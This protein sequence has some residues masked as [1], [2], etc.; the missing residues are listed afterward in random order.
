[1]DGKFE[2]DSI[3]VFLGPSLPQIQARE[4]LDASYYP[5]ARRGDVYRIMTSGIDTI[6]LIDGVFHNAPSVWQRELL[7]AIE[8][9]FSVFGA[10]SM[11]AL[12]AAELYEFGMIGHGVVFE[13]YRD[14]VIDGDDEVALLHATEEFDFRPL[15]VPLVNIR[16][17]LDRAVE[18]RYLTF[19]Q[20]VGVLEHLERMPY[21]ERSFQAVL[22]SPIFKDPSPEVIS[23]LDIYLSD[24][25]V[26]IKMQD[27]LGLLHR[28]KTTR[29]QEKEAPRRT[30][31]TSV[32]K[33]QY[34]RALMTGFYTPDGAIMGVEI[35]QRIQESKRF[36]EKMRRTLSLRRFILEWINQNQVH[37]P[38]D[39]LKT[40][41][42]NFEASNN[43]SDFAAWLCKNGL[44]Y[45]SFASALSELTLVDWVNMKGPGHFGLRW[46]TRDDSIAELVITSPPIASVSSMVLKKM[47]HRDG[48][49]DVGDVFQGKSSYAQYGFVI[50]WANRNGISAEDARSLRESDDDADIQTKNYLAWT[51]SAD[52]T[53]SRRAWKREVLLADWVVAQ[54]PEHFGLDWIFEL[55]LLRILQLTDQVELFDLVP[56]QTPVA[57]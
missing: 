48:V 56:A 4:I 49:D 8:E 25:A 37:C 28:V 47:V 21:P 1:M 5:P 13:W 18:D 16:Y 31:T 38:D 20:K 41:F 6:V 17:T 9:G 39:V 35:L 10:S 34:D 33:Q 55:D 46:N 53:S 22:D 57:R 27:A 12:R 2:Q 50:E 40:A 44:T 23:R 29:T 14:G 30:R 45:S 24:K 3:A 51:H 11:G 19:E 36:L 54:G 52:M 43:I 26:D 7:D 15:S 42:D 32:T